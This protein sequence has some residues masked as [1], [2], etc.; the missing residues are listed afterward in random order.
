MQGVRFLQRRDTAAHWAAKNPVL[1]DGE[2]GIE[3]DTGVI[4]VGDGVTSWTELEAAFESRFL[5]ILGKAV[6]SFKLDGLPPSA[7][8][9]TDD[10]TIARVSYV[11]DRTLPASPTRKLVSHWG[12]GTSFPVV[13]VLPGDTFV[14]SDVGTNGSSWVYVGGSSG[15]NGWVHKGPIVCTSTTRPAT[16]VAYAGLHIYETDTKYEAIHDGTNWV[17]APGGDCLYRITDGAG[18]STVQNINLAVPFAQAVYTSPEITQSAD[19]TQFTLLRGGVWSITF[20]FRI[21]S[22]TTGGYRF[23]S[24]LTDQAGVNLVQNDG[25]NLVN[26]PLDLAVSLTRRFPANQVIVPI[27]V[28]NS[29]AVALD[30]TANAGN[31]RN[32][33]SAAFVRP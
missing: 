21:V 12:S 19:K 25:Q 31:T 16:A 26:Q 23:V 3:K 32:F 24:Q 18:I 11:D 6:D 14:R 8:L 9:K 7:Y 15:K 4:K 22:Q 30:T 27:V 13:G 33:F 29:P 10:A 17:Y 5:P 2:F 28:S 1:G 20:G